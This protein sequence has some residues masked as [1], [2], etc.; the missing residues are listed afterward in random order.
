VSI[1]HETGPAAIDEQASV[2]T[3]LDGSNVT[4]VG[5]RFLATLQTE[6]NSENPVTVRVRRAAL[7]LGVVMARI[8]LPRIKRACA[9]VTGVAEDLQP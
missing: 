6:N 7:S 8:W 9:T 3:Q 1:G 4:P 2:R 5:Q